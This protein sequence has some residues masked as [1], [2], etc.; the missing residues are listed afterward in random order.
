VF[1][2]VR[3]RPG[4]FGATLPVRERAAMVD[5]LAAL[6]RAT[7]AASRA[8]MSRVELPRREELQVALGELGRPWRSGPFAEPARAL[9]AAAR[10]RIRDR[11]ATFD[12]LAGA[13][14]A[15]EPVITH[16]EPHPGNVLRVSTRSAGPVLPPGPDRVLVDW[17]T[18]GLG[19]PERDLW[20]VTGAADP[21]LRRYAELT[22]RAVEAD[23]LAFYRLRWALDDLSAFTRRLRAEHGRTADTEHAWLSL[24]QT[25]AI[26]A[27]D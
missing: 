3:G 2:F 25:V 8:A 21:L 13:A 6:H 17:D 12:W 16:G 24:E 22:G 14:L 7:P 15:A 5:M 4:R 20:F 23:L 27:A 11:L 9:L 18:V 26:L 1:R 10:A 19:P